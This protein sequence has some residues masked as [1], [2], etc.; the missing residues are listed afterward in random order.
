MIYGHACFH[1]NQ[2][3]I[4]SELQYARHTVHSPR[5]VQGFFKAYAPGPIDHKSA[6]P[7]L[8]LPAPIESA[9]I[10]VGWFHV[11]QVHAGLE[12]AEHIPVV[13]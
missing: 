3:L 10:L 4:Y 7:R 5:V 6:Y 12:P 2:H 8:L 13:A 11:P 1:F 9:T